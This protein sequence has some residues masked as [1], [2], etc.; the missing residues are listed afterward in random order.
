V[1]TQRKSA[2]SLLFVQEEKHFFK[3]GIFLKEKMAKGKE[4]F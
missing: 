1:K 3:K 2:K 4:M